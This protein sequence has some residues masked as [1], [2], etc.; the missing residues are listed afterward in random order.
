MILAVAGDYMEGVVTLPFF[1]ALVSGGVRLIASTLASR[2]VLS[3]SVS[4]VG[5]AGQA[6]GSNYY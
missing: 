3:C 4:L 1:V 2:G 6:G 5:L